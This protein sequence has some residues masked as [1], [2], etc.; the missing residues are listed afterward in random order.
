VTDRLLGSAAPDPQLAE[1]TL[2]PPWHSRCS[3]HRQMCFEPVDDDTLVTA[4]GGQILRNRTALDDQLKQQLTTLQ[5]TIK[6]FASAQ[7]HGQ[8]RQQ[9]QS[10]MM[11]MMA[12][13]RR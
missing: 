9:Q 11:M 13:L 12:M 7:V 1:T 6:D 4:T 5:S 8:T 10:T 2:P 3:H